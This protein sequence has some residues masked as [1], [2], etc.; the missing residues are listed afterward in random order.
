MLLLTFL[1]LL[2]PDFKACD[3]D[4]LRWKNIPQKWFTVWLLWFGVF[5]E[6]FKRKKE[7]DKC[8]S[9][10]T[11]SFNCCLVYWWIQAHPVA[12]SLHSVTKQ[13]L[14]NRPFGL[15]LLKCVLPPPSDRDKARCCWVSR[16][17][18]QLSCLVTSVATVRDALS[19]RQTQTVRRMQSVL[20]KCTLLLCLLLLGLLLKKISVG[21]CHQSSYYSV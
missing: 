15:C 9:L 5:T 11:S 13:P 21:R 16:G 14:L 20:N 6:V 18:G 17:W 19:A 10:M 2:L 8:Q 1:P 12:V 7:E 4:I 3:S